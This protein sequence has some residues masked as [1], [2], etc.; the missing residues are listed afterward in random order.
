MITGTK[1]EKKKKKTTAFIIP[2]EPELLYSEISSVD[3]QA[4]PI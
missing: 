3:H 2:Q 4:I 1:R